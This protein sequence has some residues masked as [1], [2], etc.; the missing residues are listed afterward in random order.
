MDPKGLSIEGTR[1]ERCSELIKK[2]VNLP[3][4]TISG[5]SEYDCSS[6]TFEQ[7]QKGE[8]VVIRTPVA[9]GVGLIVKFP[10]GSK[11]QTANR[12]FAYFELDGTGYEIH[13]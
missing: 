11:N 4:G 1:A 13:Y 5:L 6:A 10:D 7:R 3:D 8:V 2:I 9:R 12:S